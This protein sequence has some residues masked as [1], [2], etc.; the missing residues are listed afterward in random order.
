MKKV[1]LALSVVLSL[2]ACKPAEAKEKP[3]TWEKYGDWEKS[4]DCW[5]IRTKSTIGYY[6][7]YGR[8]GGW[9]IAKDG[10]GKGDDTLLNDDKL[11]TMTVNGFRFDISASK[12][13][14]GK[15]Q[16]TIPSESQLHNFLVIMER[17]ETLVIEFGGVKINLSTNGVRQAWD[18]YQACDYDGSEIN[19]M[20]NG[21][22]ENMEE[23]KRLNSQNKQ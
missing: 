13:K 2:V 6:L 11:K 22:M 19:D 18:A 15:V 17:V 16:I 20:I 21:I 3:V 9:F 10:S 7:A 4:S 5:S 1:L 8:F 12:S 23:M 14:S